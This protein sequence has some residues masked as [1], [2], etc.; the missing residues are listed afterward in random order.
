[1]ANNYHYTFEENYFTGRYKNV[2][3]KFS[4]KELQQSRNWFTAWL[5]KLNRYVPVEQGEGRNALEIGCA[6]GG[7]SSLLAE[8][9]FDVTAS[10]IS[11]YAVKKAKKLLP[12]IQFVTFDVQKG[13]P[14]K[15]KFDLIIAFEVVEHLED[16][17]RAF[18]N[19]YNQLN[20]EGYLV[21][22]TPYPYP[23]AWHDPTHINVLYP[24]EWMNMVR[25]VGFSTAAYHKFS[26]LPFFYK[27][28]PRFQIAI[29][30]HI[31]LA[32]INNPIFIIGKKMSEQK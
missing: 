18:K 10:D 9:G 29:P 21:F 14:I 23:W 7:V 17:E 16:P 2:V 27:L 19:I 11:K 6:I 13:I 30:F 31:P 22:S 24:N 20:P 15:K 4:Q 5:R 32:Y 25:R 8:R 3:G 26:L 12:N 1:M 28:H